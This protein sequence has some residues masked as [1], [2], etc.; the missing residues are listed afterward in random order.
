[1]GFVVL[2]T[3]ISAFSVELMGRERGHGQGV[4]KSTHMGVEELHFSKDRMV[5]DNACS[6]LADEPIAGYYIDG[7]AV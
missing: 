2:R 3:F 6:T 1:M 4:R 7:G 5:K